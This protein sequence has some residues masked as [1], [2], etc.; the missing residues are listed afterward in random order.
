MNLQMFQMHIPE[1]KR[2]INSANLKSRG[3]RRMLR[4]FVLATVEI[5]FGLEELASDCEEKLLCIST[6]WLLYCSVVAT[7][8]SGDDEEGDGSGGVRSA[9]VFKSDTTMCDES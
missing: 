5:L 7:V 6:N 1:L 4:F 9:T 8:L 3:T 2:A